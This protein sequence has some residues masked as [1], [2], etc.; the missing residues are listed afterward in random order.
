M[1][2]RYAVADT[3]NPVWYGAV[4]VLVLP[5]IWPFATGPWPAAQ[6]AI[7][8]L[9][10]AGL[11]LLGLAGWRLALPQ[12]VTASW[13]VAAGIS[14]LIGVA[15]YLGLSPDLQPATRLD[16]HKTALKIGIERFNTTHSRVRRSFGHERLPGRLQ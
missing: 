4:V 10:C 12:A 11:L 9:A 13:M 5:W 1:A 3:G 15:Q 7:V 14:S 2:S 16:S 6:Q 8:T